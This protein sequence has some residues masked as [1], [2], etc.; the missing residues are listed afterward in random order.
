MEKYDSIQENDEHAY[1][2]EELVAAH[3][4]SA[5]HKAELEQDDVCGVFIAARCLAPRKSSIGT[6]MRVLLFVLT[7]ILILSS[8]K[9][10]VMK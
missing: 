4:H 8:E 2:V 7:A 3:K 6:M 5:N 9:V 10:L 1:T